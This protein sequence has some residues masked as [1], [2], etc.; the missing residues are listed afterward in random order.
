MKG[1]LL[2]SKPLLYK[3]TNLLPPV[4]EP[5]LK[6]DKRTYAVRAVFKKKYDTIAPHILVYQ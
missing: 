1:G 5:L 6:A 4:K 2:Q 3:G